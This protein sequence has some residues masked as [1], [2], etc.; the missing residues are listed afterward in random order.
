MAVPSGY[1]GYGESLTQVRSHDDLSSGT[2]SDDDSWWSDSE[3]DSD[4]A[5]IAPVAKVRCL[6]RFSSR[7]FKF[8]G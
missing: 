4:G 5:P 8:D 3:A 2:S 7:T 1:D 6:P